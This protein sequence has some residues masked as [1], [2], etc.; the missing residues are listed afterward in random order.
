MPPDEQ[1]NNF[2][3]PAVNR[4][5]VL[6]D[7]LLFVGDNKDFAIEILHRAGYRVRDVVVII[8][9]QLQRRDRF[10][11]RRLQDKWGFRLHRLCTMDQIVS[12]MI[13]L[14]QITDEQLAAL[15]ADYRRYARWELPAFTT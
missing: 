8:D 9:R 6:I 7:D 1:R 3:T 2:I 11:G 5:V 4:D 15:R 14:G 12:R 10:G 13:D